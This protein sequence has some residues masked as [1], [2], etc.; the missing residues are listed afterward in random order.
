MGAHRSLLGVLLTLRGANVRR[1]PSS[2]S[3]QLS[4]S[5][6]VIFFS[7]TV[8]QACSIQPLRS[9]TG[10]SPSRLLIV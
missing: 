9:S 4:T 5:E 6:V 2:S 7:G 8:T 10:S 3:L 1:R